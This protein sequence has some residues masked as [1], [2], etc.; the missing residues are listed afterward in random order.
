MYKREKTMKLRVRITAAAAAALLVFSLTPCSAA[1]AE[2]A[3]IQTTQAGT[4]TEECSITLPEELSEDEYRITDSLVESY[5]TF[6]KDQSIGVSLPDGAQGLYLQW[7]DFTS[8]YTV[9]QFDAGGAMLSEEPAQP[10]I[11]AYYPLA[12]GAVRVVVAMSG[13]TS[14]S[15]LAVYGAGELPEDVQ[16]WQ[17]ADSADLLVVASTP[18][19]AM[20]EFFGVIATYA[21]NHDI[22]AA[23]VVMSLSS[24]S[25]QEELLAAL[26]HTGF[27]S[28]PVFGGFFS[29]NNDYYKT[30]RNMWGRKTTQVFLQEQVA[31][32]QPKIIVTHAADETAPDGA[33][34][35]TGEYARVASQDSSVQ[36]LYFAGE[37]GTTV[38]DYNTPLN[39]CGG[40]TVMELAAEALKLCTTRHLFESELIPVSS[41]R[42]EESSAGED[43]TGNDLFEHVDP[44][45]LGNY[46]DPTP[47]PTA[48]PTPADTPEPTAAP[49]EQ[50]AAAEPDRTVA[51]LGVSRPSTALLIV[52]P[53]VGLIATIYLFLGYGL[54]RINGRRRGGAVTVSLLPLLL[55]LAVSGAVYFFSRTQGAEETPVET[56][57]PTASATPEQTATPQP[58]PEPQEEAVAPSANDNYY[59]KA[60][61]PAEVIVADKENGHWEYRTD[62]LSILIDRVVT[63]YTNYGEKTFPLVYFIAHIRMRDVNH[64]RTVQSADNRNGAGAVKPWVI[65]RRNKA[66]LMITG[67]NLTESDTQYK[68]ILI[69]D[70]KVFLDSAK[71]DVLA[72][73]PDMTMRIFSPKETT[74]SELLMD[75]V[76]DAFSFGPTL[77][78]DGAY[79]TADIDHVPRIANETNPRTGIG[80]I[81][82]GHFVAIVVDGR[83]KEYSYGMRLSAFGELFVKEGCVEAYNLDGGVSAC[84]LFM[85]EQLNRHGNKHEGTIADTYQR[86]IPDGLVWGYSE[87]VPSEDDTIINDGDG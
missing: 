27:D 80:M 32:L 45:T 6:T 13:K 71:C 56:P 16:R 7:Y 85:G 59:R 64:F 23:L 50:T 37:G 8:R 60:D 49:A 28:Y 24:R 52:S 44:A 55:G 86:R 47:A 74:A 81:E 5:Q 63:E 40:K 25:A 20:D 1:R 53:A 21:C 51:S 69:R 15:T 46:V 33:A 87:Q 29:E 34:Q 48:T 30:V 72:M 79:T 84:M 3:R 42:L 58:T 12:A 67:D 65:A 17:P 82:P 11:N 76:R 54:K 61:D 35:F 10:F 78:R 62:T 18:Y 14:L 68:S 4:V 31:R 2:I 41:F 19:T 22:P 75:G 70:G 39:G 73:Y 83:Q 57:V 38:L 43:T 77:I 36:K 26:W 66:V 9:S